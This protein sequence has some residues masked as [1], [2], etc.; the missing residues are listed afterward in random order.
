MLSV[1]I[2]LD[3]IDNNIIVTHNDDLYRTFTFTISI[4]MYWIE[5]IGFYYDYKKKTHSGMRDIKPAAWRYYRKNTI[6]NVLWT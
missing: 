3:N 1:Y 4:L 2:L 6:P 5:L